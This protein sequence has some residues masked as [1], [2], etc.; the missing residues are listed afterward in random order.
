ME[1]RNERSEEFRDID[2][3]LWRLRV[4]DDYYSITLNDE[5]VHESW[6]TEVLKQWEDIKK[7]EAAR[8]E[9]KA[10]VKKDNDEKVMTLKKPLYYFQ[11]S[12]SE[13]YDWDD[14]NFWVY[15]SYDP[16]KFFTY[17]NAMHCYNNTIKPDPRSEGW[18]WQL[19]IVRELHETILL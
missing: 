10:S 14:W 18:L 16:A 13:D 2:G 1:I 15:D 7:D 12:I 3:A 5:T 19:V 6:S 17:E 4:L 8:F 11:R 9:E